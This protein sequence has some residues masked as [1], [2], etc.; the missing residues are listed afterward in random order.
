MVT[1]K[2]ALRAVEAAEFEFATFVFVFVAFDTFE[3]F[4]E[5]GC[6]VVI[7]DVWHPID[8]PAINAAK[9]MRIKVLYV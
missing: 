9:V 2:L 4:T 1:G 5:T 6:G 8:P 7:G 3:L